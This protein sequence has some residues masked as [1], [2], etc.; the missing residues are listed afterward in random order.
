M[1]LSAALILPLVS[2]VLGQAASCRSIRA[3]P[4]TRCQHRR[5]ARPSRFIADRVLFL[6]TLLGSSTVLQ[7]L[8]S[9]VLD[10]PLM[11]RRPSMPTRLR[12]SRLA[13]RKSSLP[14]GP[15]TSETTLDT[16]LRSWMLSQS[17]TSAWS[18]F[19]FGGGRSRHEAWSLPL[20]WWSDARLKLENASSLI[21]PFTLKQRHRNQWWRS[22]SVAFR[23]WHDCRARLAQQ[24]EPR[25]TLATRR[26]LFGAQRRILGCLVFRHE[27]PADYLRPRA[28]SEWSNR[29]AARQ[30]HPRSWRPFGLWRQ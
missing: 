19:R 15:A 14:F 12:T 4:E 25:W 30:G 3:R 1:L 16:T 29:L 28:R 7:N 11:V 23:R 20:W 10:R 18:L 22:P 9:S 27:R 2:S 5:A 26:I 24:Y 6:Q 21:Y 17:C 8:S 13:V